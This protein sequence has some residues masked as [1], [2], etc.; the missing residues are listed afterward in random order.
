MLELN[1]T[2][3]IVNVEDFNKMN[4]LEQSA[5]CLK[6]GLDIDS[7]KKL[8]NSFKNSGKYDYLDIRGITPLSKDIMRAEGIN[9]YNKACSMAKKITDPQK[10]IRRTKAVA[11]EFGIDSNYTTAF[12]NEM[13]YKG[14]TKEQ[15]DDLIQSI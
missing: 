5:F 1:I 14:F 12:L 6:H 15:V 10:M 13:L 3:A 8:T 7:I 2:D 11:K 9:S 4:L